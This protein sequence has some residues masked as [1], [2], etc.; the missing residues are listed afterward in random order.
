VVLPVAFRW[1][2][3][4]LPPIEKELLFGRSFFC[5]EDFEGSG[6]FPG[7]WFLPSVV[8]PAAF[9]WKNPPL[10]THF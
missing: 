3:P 6:V 8:L 7:D 10:P 9:R 4:S 5:F 1:K 2:N